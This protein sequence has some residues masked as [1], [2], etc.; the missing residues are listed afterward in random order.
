MAVM[1]EFKQRIEE[2]RVEGHLYIN[3]IEEEISHSHEFLTRQMLEMEA[4]NK[5]VAEL[6]F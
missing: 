6:V 5:R 3:H 1:N 4:L 2:G